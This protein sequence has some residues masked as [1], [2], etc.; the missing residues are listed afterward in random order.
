MNRQRPRAAPATG[1]ERRMRWRLSA[2]A[3]LAG[4]V[5]L[6]SIAS[7]ITIDLNLTSAWTGPSYSQDGYT[8]TSG[9][10]STSAYLNWLLNPGSEGNNA[11]GANPTLATNFSSSTNTLTSDSGPFNFN[12]IKLADMWN[13]ATGGGVVF[14]FYHTNGSVNSS[15]ITLAA[16][17]GLQTFS[18]N[19]TDLVKVVFQPTFFWPAG[20]AMGLQFDFVN[21]EASAVPLPAALPLF[22]AGL[23]AMGLFGWRR[24]RKAA[25]HA[26]S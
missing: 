1:E 14:S 3:G 13:G 10:N 20:D 18:F 8:F 2:F 16:I 19:Q 6:S 12:S 24:K 5:A 15:V 26:A 4:L 22:A 7:A 23:G 21:V 25:A 11:N 9:V 17:S